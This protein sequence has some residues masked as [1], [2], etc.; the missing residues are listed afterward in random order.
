[1]SR[2]ALNPQHRAAGWFPLYRS[3]FGDG[4]DLWR[5]C[6]ERRDWG[7]W[8]AW[9][10]LLSKTHYGETPKLVPYIGKD[11][12][13]EGALTIHRGEFWVSQR[14]LARVMGW[15]DDEKGRSKARRFY[16]KMEKMGRIA[17][18]P[19]NA[20]RATGRPTCR[21]TCRPTWRVHKVN[22]YEH[23]NFGKQSGGQPAG[24]P[25]DPIPKRPKKDTTRDRKKESVLWGPQTTW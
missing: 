11:G 17:P 24:Q 16:V 18:V 5:E 13:Q 21:P 14:L 7:E 25:A 4:D 15:G 1:M 8:A 22:N 19:D 23:Y 12:R 2:G 10:Y 20:E 3:V 6:R 9:L